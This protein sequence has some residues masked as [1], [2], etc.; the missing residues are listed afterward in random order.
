MKLYQAGAWTF[1]KVDH[2]NGKAF[3]TS[4]LFGYIKDV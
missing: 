1:Q 2:T 3:L 4:S